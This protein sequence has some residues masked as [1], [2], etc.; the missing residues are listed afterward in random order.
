MTDPSS[1]SW[2]DH[3]DLAYSGMQK[4]V[5]QEEFKAIN[6]SL[7]VQRN[8]IERQQ[9]ESQNQHA[10]V[11]HQTAEQREGDPDVWQ[12]SGL[13]QLHDYKSE[14]SLQDHEPLTDAVGEAKQV[15]WGNIMQVKHFVETCI[16]SYMTKNEVVEA[17]ATHAKI[18]PCVTHHVWQ[19]LEK[20]NHDFFTRYYI[21]LKVK[22]Q[23][24]LFNDLLEKQHQVMAMESALDF[25]QLQLQTNMQP[26]VGSTDLANQLT[27]HSIH[28][29]HGHLGADSKV[30]RVMEGPNPM[31]SSLFDS[32]SMSNMDF[33]QGSEMLSNEPYFSNPSMP[34]GTPYTTLNV[35]DLNGNGFLHMGSF[36]GMP[37]PSGQSSINRSMSDLSTVFQRNQGSFSGPSFLSSS[38]DAFMSNPSQN[39]G[40]SR[41][42]GPVTEPVY[43]TYGDKALDHRIQDYSLL[44]RSKL[45]PTQP[46]LSKSKT[47]PLADG[48]NVVGSK[49]SLGAKPSVEV[50]PPSSSPLS[51][52]DE[53]RLVP[54]NPSVSIPS[55]PSQSQVS[56]DPQLPP[57]RPSP[58]TGPRKRSR[59]RSQNSSSPRGHP[60]ASSSSGPSWSLNPWGKGISSSSCRGSPTPALQT[61]AV[62]PPPSWGIM[63]LLKMQYPNHDNWQVDPPSTEPN[64][65]AFIP[66]QDDPPPPPSAAMCA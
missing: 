55:K 35:L 46:V 57:P 25:Q 28:S 31:D 5:P 61:I 18:P 15:T 17:L 24:L 22:E 8:E 1:L 40:E 38:M 34:S 33:N 39:T 45:A 59:L 26:S 23:I 32:S 52:R 56:S 48:W 65:G 36:E 49:K 3:Y 4:S 64:S 21:W 9:L 20:E 53:P 11:F 54:P 44:A 6:G 19:R 14:S 60:S 62:S 2:S 16:K 42:V 41:T 66:P 43:D 27:Q 7:E 29:S 10:M 58:P 63:V 50:P 51:S 30:E 37:G 47:D 13:G 12:Q